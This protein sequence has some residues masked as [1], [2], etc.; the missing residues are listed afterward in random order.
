M[1]DDTSQTPASA[2]NADIRISDASPRISSVGDS[3][4]RNGMT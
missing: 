4:N 3:T 2:V 1:P